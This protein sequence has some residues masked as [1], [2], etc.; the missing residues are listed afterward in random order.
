MLSPQAAI[1]VNQN[2]SISYKL[3]V[4]ISPLAVLGV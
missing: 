2:A 3:K 4:E 1:F